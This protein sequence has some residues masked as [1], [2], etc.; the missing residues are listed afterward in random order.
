VV[1]GA[2]GGIGGIGLEGARGLAGQ[3]RS[4]WCWACGPPNGASPRPRR[5]GMPVPRVGRG[6][7]A[8]SGGSDQRPSIRRSPWITVRRGR[9][10]GQQRRSRRPCAADGQV[11]STYIPDHGHCP[12]TAR[13]VQGMARIPVRAGSGLVLGLTGVSAET[14]GSSVTS[15][16]RSPGTACAC[17][18]AVTVM[19]G[20]EERTRMLS[21]PFLA[22]SPA[23]TVA[24]SARMPTVL[25]V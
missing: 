24:L 14:P 9:T 22:L 1:T 5:S 21:G 10:A 19:L 6:D 20:L 4:R 18:P 3:G 13:T 17:C 7:N 16:V 12:V 15:R 23:R 11:H 25:S 8:R 2:S